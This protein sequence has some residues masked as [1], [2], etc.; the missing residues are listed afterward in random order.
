MN[1]ADKDATLDNL[2]EML[3]KVAKSSTEGLTGAQRDRRV[4]QRVAISRAIMKLENQALAT[5]VTALGVRAVDVQENI[6]ETEDELHGVT[7]T[8]NI[9]R[10]VARAM[11]SIA[12]IAAIV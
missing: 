11:S 9:I 2:R 10:T 3:F 1:E 12:R 4:A 8:L 5:I 7:D 6:D